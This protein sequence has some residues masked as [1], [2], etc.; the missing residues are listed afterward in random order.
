MNAS[1][2][3]YL[4]LSVGALGLAVLAGSQEHSTG[5]L[6][7]SGPM[8]RANAKQFPVALKILGRDEDDKTAIWVQPM[9]PPT[10][11]VKETQGH[12]PDRGVVLCREES[13]VLARMEGH[14]GFY[15]FFECEEGIELVVAREDFR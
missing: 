9:V 14:E 1:F 3:R 15:I 8:Y 6:V 12:L 4:A 2:K 13:Q 10:V 7:M 11:A 5:T